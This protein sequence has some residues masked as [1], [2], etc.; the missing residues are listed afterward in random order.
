MQCFVSFFILMNLPSNLLYQLGYQLYRGCSLNT[1]NAF[2]AQR[3]ITTKAIGN[4]I[5]P[6]DNSFLNKPGIIYNA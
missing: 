1:P 5:R 3:N 6:A 2:L 4:N